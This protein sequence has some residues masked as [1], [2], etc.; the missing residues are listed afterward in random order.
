[1]S[2]NLLSHWCRMSPGDVFSTLTLSVYTIAWTSKSL[3]LLTTFIVQFSWSLYPINHYISSITLSL[4]QRDKYQLS[5]IP[6]NA[7]IKYESRI[8]FLWPVYEYVMSEV[9]VHHPWSFLIHSSK[10]PLTR[11]HSS[12]LCVIS[13]CI[14]ERRERTQSIISCRPRRYTNKII[15]SVYMVIVFHETPPFCWRPHASK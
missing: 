7:K 10:S 8:A 9:S 13:P 12:C 2:S 14:P 6:I 11:R 15:F 4:F 1:M 5:F 3:E